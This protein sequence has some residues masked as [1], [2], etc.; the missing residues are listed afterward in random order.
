VFDTTKIADR[1]AFS[2]K[3]AH[4]KKRHHQC[5]KPKSIAMFLVAI[6]G[7]AAGF[8]G[9]SRLGKLF[10]ALVFLSL[11]VHMVLFL[12][13]VHKLDDEIIDGDISQAKVPRIAGKMQ[14]KFIAHVL[15]HLLLL[16]LGLRFVRFAKLAEAEEVHVVEGPVVGVFCAL[17]TGDDSELQPGTVTGKSVEVV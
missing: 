11:I 5:G 10:V 2:G 3:K 15:K 17:P 4:H 14:I 9:K 16:V 1:K 8:T 6:T 12:K 13:K 7:I